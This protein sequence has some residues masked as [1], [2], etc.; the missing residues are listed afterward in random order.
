MPTHRAQTFIRYDAPVIPARSKHVNPRNMLARWFAI[1]HE[2]TVQYSTL[3]PR[4]VN[5]YH[6]TAE[7]PP[8]IQVRR[9]FLTTDV[10]SPALQSLVAD[11]RA[12]ALSILGY[13]PDAESS[14]LLTSTR[15]HW[16]RSSRT[17]GR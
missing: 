10:D 6:V 12:V 3:I 9:F 13:G 7:V 15:R 5:S 17:C 16:T 4:A 14:L 1:R 11:M 2:F 8:E